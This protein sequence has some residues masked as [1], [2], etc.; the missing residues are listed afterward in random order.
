MK[1]TDWIDN[2][3][4]SG[5]LCDEYIEKVR[6]AIS[7]KQIMDIVLDANGQTFLCEMQNKNIGLPYETI[8][9]EFGNYINGRYIATI[10]NKYTST[11]YCCYGM[12]NEVT[13]ES[14]IT[15]FLGCS[16]L[17]IKIPSNQRCELTFDRNC[18][19]IV[20]DC[21]KTSIVYLNDYSDNGVKVKK[22]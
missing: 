8:I 14:T 3:I 1:F 2:I 11:L 5:N 18:N 12:G 4:E 6:K 22:K 20:I 17:H 9:N 16:N 13:I 21:P 10:D 15:I 19:N 7:K